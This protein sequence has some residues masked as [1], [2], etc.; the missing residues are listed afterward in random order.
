MV[1]KGVDHLVPCVYAAGK[2]IEMTKLEIAID[3][4]K[5][6]DR[7]VDALQSERAL[8]AGM[9]DR[10]RAA[11]SP[12]QSGLQLIAPNP[13]S[14]ETSKVYGAKTAAMRN[15]IVG[16]GE[17]GASMKDLKAAAKS[18]STTANF[19]YRFI[20]RLKDSGEIVER[21]SKFIA[22]D[23]LKQKVAA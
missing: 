3:E 22:T 14:A 1:Q 12:A 2:V 20:G 11:N 9:A 5:R 18:I 10:E 21:G 6:I 13:V 16:K 7:E 19:V 4:L 17:T 8:W 15:F 23:K